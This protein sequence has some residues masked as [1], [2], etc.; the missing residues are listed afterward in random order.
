[1]KKLAERRSLEDAVERVRAK[2][3]LLS[4]D[5]LREIRDGLGLTQAELAKQLGLGGN[6]IS[7]WEANRVVQ[8]KSLDLLL[9]LVRDV[10]A[11]ATYLKRHR[12]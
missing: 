12:R 7:R 10:P 5:E 9:R 11:A 4:G 2:L 6:T 8:N 1:M 3:G